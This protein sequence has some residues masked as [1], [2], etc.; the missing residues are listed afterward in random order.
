MRFPTILAILAFLFTATPA[1]ASPKDELHDAF[2]KFLAAKSFRATITDLGKG[3]TISTLEFVAPDRY[4]VASKGST[5]LIV[6]DA[7]YVDINGQLT[8]MPVPGVGKLTAQYRNEAFLR[9]VEGGMTVQALPDESVDG[10]PAKVYAYTVTEPAKAEAKTW[11]SQRTG[12]PIQT[13]SSGRFMGVKSST[14]TRY[15]GFDDPSIRIDAP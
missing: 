7:M 11:I 14:R 4:R 15:S 10:E 2:V 6:G 5:Q 13:D 3:E 12:L 8:R 9:Q 1:G